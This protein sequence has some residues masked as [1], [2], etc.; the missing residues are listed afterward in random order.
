MSFFQLYLIL[1]EGTITA[2]AGMASLPILQEI[3]V[4]ERR[5]LTD[6]QIAQAVAISQ[7]TP[8]PNA[9]YVVCI[10]YF[11]GGVS[12]AIAGWLA[13][14]TPSAFIIPLVHFAGRNLDH[15]RIKSTLQSVVIASAGLILAATIPL[16]RGAFTD[17]LTIVITAASLLVVLMTRLDTIW[18]VLGAA[19]LSLSASSFEIV[20]RMP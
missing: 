7:S 13:M 18:I 1:L 4:S 12:G 6:A 17:W 14:I 15:P 20:A 9:L 5:L 19:A 2:F 10:G 16:A 3:L 11:V 8:G